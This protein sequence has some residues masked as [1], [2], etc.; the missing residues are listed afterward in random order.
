[1][2]RPLP[3]FNILIAFNKTVFTGLKSAIKRGDF[4]SFLGANKD[5]VLFTNTSDNFI[6]LAH[7]YSF[8]EK[9]GK[10]TDN[11]TITLELLDPGRVFEQNYLANSLKQLLGKKTGD[12]FSTG[13]ETANE[14]KRLQNILDHP[15]TSD[16]MFW[17]QMGEAKSVGGTLENDLYTFKTGL[18]NINKTKK[19]N[20]NAGENYYDSKE[21]AIGNALDQFGMT[22][23]YGDAVKV[24]KRDT[25]YEK[26][27]ADFEKKKASY[28]EDIRARLDSLQAPVMPTN[29]YISYGCGDNLDNWAGPFLCNMSGAKIGFSAETGFRTIT[30]VFTTNSQFPGLTPNDAA[31]FEF[32]RELQILAQVPL[33]S[34]V[35]KDHLGYTDVFGAASVQNQ[36]IVDEKEF[37]K[38]Q[39]EARISHLHLDRSRT[40]VLA[41]ES[42][43][44]GFDYH[45]VI[46][47]CLKDYIQKATSNKANVVVFFPDLNELLYPLI[48]SYENTFR[49]NNKDFNTAPITLDL[50]NGKTVSLSREKLF[51]IPEILKEL[52]FDVTTE[53][54]SDG[55]IITYDPETLISPNGTQDANAKNIERIKNSATT[56]KNLY[57][58]LIKKPGQSFMDPLRK[59]TSGFSI[60]KIIQPVFMIEN[61]VDFIKE[62]KTF[63]DDHAGQERGRRAS[64]DMEKVRL[65]DESGRVEE[66]LNIDAD[67]PILIYGDSTIL[68]R[69]FFGKIILERTG[70][71]KYGYGED[72][73]ALEKRESEK[74]AGEATT[75]FF[76]YQKL[77]A[78]RDLKYITEK[79]QTIAQKYF[80]TVKGDSC[81]NS[82]SLPKSEF[83]FNSKDELGIQKANIPVFKFG[84]QDS[85][86]LDIDMDINQH[87]FAILN[88]I[89]YQTTALHRG[90]RG[91]LNKKDDAFNALLQLD[92]DKIAY[93]IKNYTV[94]KP[95]GKQGLSESGIEKAKTIPQFADVK[96]EDIEA[97]FAALITLS[98][99]KT[100]VQ[101]L[102]WWKSENPAVHFTA[103]LSQ[104]A[105]IAYKGTIRTLPFFHLSKNVGSLNPALLFVKETSIL[106]IN[107][108]NSISD[109]LNGLWV[110]YG[111]E[112][113]IGREDAHSSF[114]IMKDISYQMPNSLT[115]VGKTTVNTLN[116]KDP[117][118][119]K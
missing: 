42:P 99:D 114:H 38:K 40:E 1:M 94:I 60:T 19:L 17:D 119:T 59:V 108:N 23:L 2:S 58:S 101:N 88:S 63:C 48:K 107:K 97:A 72:A 93:I 49:F 70:V 115:P 109:V 65:G 26:F 11:F 100:V 69:Y 62:F 84:V 87:Y 25:S 20:Q 54:T 35:S 67:K 75:S 77:V 68:D 113:S 80:Q 86:V 56:G 116:V 98:G 112:H 32:G 14:I 82:Y 21:Y 36:T 117:N 8:Q 43:T 95:D 90:S 61:N 30:T 53:V 66:I 81:F 91:S 37:A 51:I 16:P 89:L 4:N 7:A 34:L 45:Y 6:R 83:A 92:K 18:D 96:V 73:D 47:E 111:Y 31:V 15:D 71:F 33:M 79:Y 28:L 9:S 78:K 105:K 24:N 102:D 85:N 5:Y 64:L 76:N 57:L 104:M 41:E 13:E 103:V 52:G 3:T 55:K 10:E 74:R 22:D 12:I 46:S 118:N 106:G 110:I 44:G 39:K 27:L 29:L 50:P